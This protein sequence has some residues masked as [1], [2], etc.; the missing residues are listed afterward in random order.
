ML[1]FSV[2][3][4]F[5]DAIE[6][7]LA[8]DGALNSRAYNSIVG[9]PV[10]LADKAV[11]SVSGVDFPSSG[12]AV[13]KVALSDQNARNLASHG[14][15]TVIQSDGDEVRL[16][17]WVRK[18]SFELV[19]GQG[20]RLA[21]SYHGCHAEPAQSFIK[22][23][24]SVKHSDRLTKNERYALLVKG[25]EFEPR[26]FRKPGG[27]TREQSLNRNDSRAVSNSQF[28]PGLRANRNAEN[29]AYS[30]A[31]DRQ[32][33][34]DPETEPYEPAP[35]RASSTPASF[36]WPAQPGSGVARAG[37]IQPITNKNGRI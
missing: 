25:T 33:H 35:A 18:G 7:V 32:R 28:G 26:S 31:Q 16:R 10:M 2:T 6:A 36:D 1:K 23:D 17:D 3:K 27:S 24:C 37:R 5:P 14:C 19:N 13:L 21:K 9:R 30:S 34:S 15:L 11:G 29:L 22:D 8:L 4:V 12:T 20:E